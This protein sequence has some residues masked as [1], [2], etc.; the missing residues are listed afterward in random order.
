MSDKT[1]FDAYHVLCGSL[2]VTLRLT[3]LPTGPVVDTDALVE[4]L[5]TKQIRAAALDVTDPEPLPAGHALRSLGNVVMTPH[6]GSQTFATRFGM[7]RLC[8]DNLRAVLIDNAPMPSEVTL[9]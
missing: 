7:F 6:W 5:R 9:T 2:L 4:A 3:A 1:S 8:V